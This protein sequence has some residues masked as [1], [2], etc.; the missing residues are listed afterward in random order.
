MDTCATQLCRGVQ[1]RNFSTQ[2]DADAVVVAVLCLRQCAAGNVKSL[3][4]LALQADVCDSAQVNA[5]G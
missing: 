3:Q 2:R 4:T 5:A 1:A